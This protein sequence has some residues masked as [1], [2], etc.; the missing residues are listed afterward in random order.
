MNMRTAQTLSLVISGFQG[1]SC[2]QKAMDDQKVIEKADEIS[3]M[4]DQI[5]HGFSY[6]TLL[7]RSLTGQTGSKD[8]WL[9]YLLYMAAHFAN[10][11]ESWQS[12]WVVAAQS[13]KWVVAALNGVV[14]VM[15]LLDETVAKTE[16]TISPVAY[17]KK[18]IVI[19]AQALLV[20]SALEPT[21]RMTAN[22]EVVRTIVPKFTTFLESFFN[23]EDTLT[24]LNVNLLYNFFQLLV[25]QADSGKPDSIRSIADAVNVGTCNFFQSL[26]SQADSTEKPDSIRS[27]TDAMNA[28]TFNFALALGQIPSKE[29]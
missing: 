24:G 5:K 25:P 21:M 14:A 19:V 2:Y 26:V 6:V 18:S 29:E 10:S 7:A 1:F 28:A 3:T 15:E 11:V 22:P 12:E 27:I 9:G 23:P 4:D 16:D 17:A 8:L 13:A 20:M